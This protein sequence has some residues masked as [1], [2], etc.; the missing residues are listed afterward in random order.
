VTKYCE[1]I[2]FSILGENYSDATNYSFS[3]VNMSEFLR[4]FKVRLAKRFY[5]NQL[6][7]SIRFKINPMARLP[8]SSI[9]INN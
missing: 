9:L 5:V 3:P 4:Y 2:N 6:L 8:V 7:F 1:E